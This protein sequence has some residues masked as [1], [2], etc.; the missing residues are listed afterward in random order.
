MNE[1]IVIS[2]LNNIKTKAINVLL[3]ENVV[4]A[5]LFVPGYAIDAIIPIII[6]PRETELPIVKPSPQGSTSSFCSFIDLFLAE[7]FSGRCQVCG[8]GRN[9]THIAGCRRNKSEFLSVCSECSYGFE[10]TQIIKGSLLGES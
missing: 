6:K 2:K 3:F 10:D 7:I 4:I 9:A 1:P 5:T 8:E